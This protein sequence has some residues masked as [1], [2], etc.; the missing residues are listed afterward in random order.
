MQIFDISNL[1]YIDSGILSNLVDV[2]ALKVSVPDGS[3]S[4]SIA[5][6]SNRFLILL[7]IVFEYTSNPNHVL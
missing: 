2:T 1:F 3:A 5:Y 4:P 7:P 6:V